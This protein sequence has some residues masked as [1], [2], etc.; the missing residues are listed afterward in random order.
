MDKMTQLRRMVS[1]LERSIAN[2]YD[3][4]SPDE[5]NTIND[6]LSQAMGFLRDKKQK[7]MAAP[8][9][10]ELIWLLAG[11]N[12]QAFRSYMTNFPNADFQSFSKN[13]QAI[14]NT[15]QNFQSRITAPGGES[16]GG[17]PHADLQSSNIYGFQYDPQN[18]QLKVRFNDG[19]TYE[20]EGVP[21]MVYK[22]FASGAIPAKTTGQNQWGAWW[23]G[24]KPSLGA[25]FHQ[26]IRDNFPYEKVA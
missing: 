20:Y 13:P 21:P 25:S 11:E 5:R 4:L 23:T 22:M 1:S 9:G 7:T 17:I 3:D 26:L 16:A 12:P 8:K 10:S 18:S 24:K 6:T 15:I 14:Q 2:H 19:G